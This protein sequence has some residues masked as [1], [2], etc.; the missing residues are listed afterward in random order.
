MRLDS[1]EMPQLDL[2][3]SVSIS[4][5]LCLLSVQQD[6]NWALSK[7]LTFASESQ[8]TMEGECWENK[9]LT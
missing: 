3:Y 2:G 1:F 8:E 4:N 5:A 9:L 7:N 6:L